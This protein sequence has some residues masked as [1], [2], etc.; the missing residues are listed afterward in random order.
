M[1]SMTATRWLAAALLALAPGLPEAAPY[2]MSPH[3]IVASEAAR[4]AEEL[5]RAFW[6]CDYIAST[7]GMQFVSL[8]LCATI[9]D[10]IK[11]E[12]FGGDYDEMVRWWQEHKPAQHL[13]LQTEESR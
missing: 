4:S 1:K 12:R 9:T 3:R 8:D 7:R 10:Q 11:T 6:I 5:E 13:R 2:T